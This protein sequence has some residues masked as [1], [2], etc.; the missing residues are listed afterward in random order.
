MWVVFI[1]FIYIVLIDFGLESMITGTVA[2]MTS[3]DDRWS[4]R[5]I[6]ITD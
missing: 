3:G 4:R 6:S 2:L 5:K 1:P